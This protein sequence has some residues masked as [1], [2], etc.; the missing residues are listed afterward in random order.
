MSVTTTSRARRIFRRIAT[1][2][3]DLDYAQRRMFELQTGTRAQSR[4][5]ESKAPSPD[6]AHL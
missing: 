2:W 4:R 6:S 5:H 3:S 1:T